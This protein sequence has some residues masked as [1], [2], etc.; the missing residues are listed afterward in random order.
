MKARVAACFDAGADIAKIAC[1]SHAEPDNARLLGLL[2]DP[3]QIVIVAMGAKG[4]I[5]RALAPL[6]GSPF[7]FASGRRAGRPQRDKWTRKRYPGSLRQSQ[8]N[9]YLRR[10]RIVTGVFAVA[11]NPIFQSRSPLIFNTA[12]RESRHH[13]ALRPSGSLDGRRNMATAREIGIKG[14]NITAPFKAGILEHLDAVEEDAQKVESVNTI[15]KRDGA[16]VGYNTDISGVTRAVKESG[17]DPSGEKAVVIGAGGA[18][19][20]AAYALIR[21]GCRVTIVNRTFERARETA[22]RLGCEA[23]PFDRMKDALSGA[24]L[25]VSAVT[26]ESSLID[27]AFLSRNM[28]VLD[29]N[30]GRPSALVGDAGRAGCR[31]IDGREWLLDQAVPAFELFTGRAAP[32]TAMRRALWKNRRDARRNI[33]LIGF[34]GAGKS[35]VAER[36]AALTGMTLV[37]IDRRIEEKA[38]TTIA[39]IF[40]AQGEDE[41]RRMEQAQIEE[42][43][44]D[45]DQVVACGGGALMNRSNVRV[46]RNNC[47]SVWLWADTQTALV[48]IGDTATRPMLRTGSDAAR[49]GRCAPRA[50]AAL[51]RAHFRPARQYGRK[52]SRRNRTKDMG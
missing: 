21:V 26:T 12:F 27:P 37:D 6:L 19:R 47:L 5:T 14:L 48:R 25:L 28:V 4:R 8:G 17:F 44:L 9:R 15:V 29:A 16:Y 49:K 43:G 24:R 22:E 10:E 38:G 30:Y 40:R 35:I 3:R 52:D 39:E 46:L 2:D 34:M 13:C 33:A 42:L 20:A 31:L 7:T 32:V 41:F 11:G 36:I 1:K 51:L 45:I 18:G 50:E 23:L